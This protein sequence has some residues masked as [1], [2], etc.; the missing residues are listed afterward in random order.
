MLGTSLRSAESRLGPLS[1]PQTPGP[2]A[3]SRAGLR[4]TEC[5]YALACVRNPT[6]HTTY[7]APTTWF[8]T[9]ESRAVYTWMLDK[10]AHGEPVNL[11]ALRDDLPYL[12]DVLLEVERD[13]FWPQDVRDSWAIERPE[14]FDADVPRLWRR[15]RDR[16]RRRRLALIGEAANVYARD[17]GRDVGE[18][19]GRLRSALDEVAR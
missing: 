17:L 16:H 2:P 7:P 14:Y 5:C 13:P 12:A 1:R 11:V 4:R 10:L 8:V 3:G 6:W 18:S 15:L 19:V 9:Y